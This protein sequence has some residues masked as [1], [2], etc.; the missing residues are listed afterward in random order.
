MNNDIIK[1][2]IFTGCLA[3]TAVGA[4]AQNSS[5][6][7][8][9]EPSNLPNE[10]LKN[11]KNYEF[12]NKRGMRDLNPN[13]IPWIPNNRQDPDNWDFP[14]ENERETLKQMGIN[15]PDFD[16]VDSTTDKDLEEGQMRQK[17]HTVEHIIYAMPGDAVSLYP[18]YGMEEY[19]TD[20]EHFLSTR[21]YL[22]TFSHWYDYK[23]GGRVIHTA[24]DGK[25][26]DL[27][28]FPHDRGYM[29]ISDNYGFYGGIYMSPG[30]SAIP[31]QGTKYIVST[32]K[33]YIDAVNA[34]NAAG[35][36]GRIVLSNDID[37][38]GR[39][40]VSMLGSDA[41][42]PFVGTIDGNGHAIKNLKMGGGY[43]VGL[44]SN[45]GDGASIYNLVLDNCTISGFAQ[46]GLVGY[47]TGGGL[48][49]KNLK[50]NDNCSIYATGP[51]IEGGG[52]TESFAGSILGRSNNGDSD[53]HLT[54]EN[55]YLGA[56]IGNPDNNMGFNTAICG[57]LNTRR[58]STPSIFKNIVV[59]CNILR[60]EELNRESYVRHLL[61][62]N[63]Y[64][65]AAGK[66]IETGK[67]DDSDINWTLTFENCYG[68]YNNFDAQDLRIWKSFN[69]GN[70]PD[71]TGWFEIIST[72]DPNLGGELLL[73]SA[74]RPWLGEED[75]EDQKRRKA[76]TSAIFYFPESLEAEWD[77]NGEYV[78]AADF[79]QTFYPDDNH[80]KVNEKQ[81]IE[82]LIAFRHIFRIRDA[83]KQTEELQNHN[84][85][86]ARGHQHR[87]TAR[88][89]S[90]FQIRLDSPL[91][92]GWG[93]SGGVTNYY[94]KNGAGKYER[95][96]QFGIKVLD[97]NDHSEL[98][99]EQ[100]F[101]FGSDI[102]MRR[103]HSSP[104]GD[105]SDPEGPFLYHSMLRKGSLPSEKHYI[106]QV[107]AKDNNGNVIRT[108]GRE[109]VLMQYDINFVSSSRASLVTE[110]E[111]YD[112]D[113]NNKYR[114][115]RDESLRE[116]YGD[117]K[118][119]IDFDNFFEL[120]KLPDDDLKK[121]MISYSVFKFDNGIPSDE[122]WYW[123]EEKNNLV[124]WDHYSENHL[125]S[126]SKMQHTFYKWPVAW[127]NSTY[128]FG[129]N[130]R[131]NY[132][133]YMLATH[134]TNVP[135]HAS[136]D[137][138]ENRA[139][140]IDNEIGLYDRLYY[141]TKRQR[142]NNPDKKIKQEQG[143]FY[144]VNA[145]SDPG[146]SARLPVELPC[147]GSR[148]I[149]SAWIAEL[150]KGNYDPDDGFEA[151][152]LSFNFVAV[153]KENN[154]RVV[155][156]NFI[157]GNI[158]QGKLGQWCNIYYS[159]IPRMSEFYND[160]K[161]FE[162]VDH[163]EL[164]LAHNGESSIGADYAIDDIRA[165][166]VPSLAEAAHDGFA[167]DD[168]ALD[169][170]VETS[171]E[172]LIEKLGKS[173]GYGDTNVPLKLYYAIT[174][175][176]KFD[177][178]SSMKDAVTGSVLFSNN[179]S[180]IPPY[181]YENGTRRDDVKPGTAYSVDSDSSD[182]TIVFETTAPA[183]ALK[184]GKEYYV[185]FKSTLADETADL[186]NLKD[187]FDLGEECSYF[188]TMT[189]KPSLKIKVDGVIQ[190][191]F[192][193]LEVCENQSPVIQLNVWSTDKE[194]VEVMKNAFF[195]WF[196]G[197]LN[198]FE[199]YR[200]K[201]YA[202]SL[203]ILD[204]YT[205][206]EIEFSLREALEVFR[207]RYP[208][209]ETVTGIKPETVKGIDDKYLEQWMLD[210]IDVASTP[211][212][213]GLPKLILHQTSFVMPP[214]DLGDADASKAYFVAIPI[215][216]LLQDGD[217]NGNGSEFSV[218]VC[219]SPTEIGVAVDN[220]T[221]LVRHGLTA[222]E[223]DY[224][225]DLYDIPLR[226]GLNQ[227][228]KSQIAAYPVE[229]RRLNMPLRL[230]TSSDG[231]AKEFSLV[232]EET[233]LNNEKVIKNGCI[234]LAQTNDPEYK[235]L[236]T[237]NERNEETEHL[238]WVG[239]MKEFSASSNQTADA[240]KR[241]Y[242]IAE[243][244][245]NF[246][247]KEGYFYRMRYQ[248]EELSDEEV[249]GD[250]EMLCKGQDVF[251]IKVVPQY[252]KWT[253]E[254]NLSWDNDENWCRLSS[255][256][257]LKNDMA[258]ADMRFT[259]GQNSNR[260]AYAPLAFT[261]VVVDK[262][263]VS[264]D[265]EVAAE[266]PWLYAPKE[267]KVAVK[268]D[269]KIS[270]T[271][272][273]T[274][275]PA[276]KDGAVE[277]R[278]VDGIG[279]PTSLIQYDMTA[280]MDAS[281][282]LCHPW[283]ANSC[284]EIHFLPGATVMNQQALNYQKAWVDVELDHSRWYLLSTPLQEVYA[285]DFYLPS[286]NA[287]QGTE[288]FKDIT[289][290]ES[291]N[292]RFSPAVYQRGWDKSMA[293]VYDFGKDEARNVAVKTFW[294]RVY[295]D[296]KENYGYGNAFSIK[297]DISS[298]DEDVEKVI[299]RLPKADKSYLYYTYGKDE[300]DSDKEFSRDETKSGRLNP[301]KGSVTVSTANEGNYFLVGNPFMTYMDVKK[302]LDVNTCLNKKYW[303][304]TDKGQIAVTF[305]GDTPY[306]AYP[307]TDSPEDVTVVA[308]MQGFFV[309]ADTK[310]SSLTLNYDETMM[311]RY[312][313]SD[314]S[315]LIQATRSENTPE[316]FK[317][318]SITEGR[319]CSAAIVVPG[320]NGNE[321]NSMNAVDNRELDIPSTVFT[322]KGGRAMSINFCD[323]AEGV[324]I[325]VIA[326]DQT[327]TTLRFEGGSALEGFYLYDTADNSLTP[328]SEVNEIEVTGN[329]SGRFYLT[330]GIEEKPIIDGISW[331]VDGNIL[332]VHDAGTTGMLD[333][334]VCDTLG[335]VIF[336][337][338][339]DDTVSVPLEK[340]LFVV[341][342]MNGEVEKSVKI[343]L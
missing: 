218:P 145:A 155:L 146:V 168:T 219:T 232:K 25:K 282:I 321:E 151:A 166:V 135:Y 173:E 230:V 197:S 316:V 28:D 223:I 130:Y 9:Q 243:F 211:G 237:V 295:N 4:A 55:V 182:R 16:F 313:V 47:H 7:V 48:T 279:N 250:D 280:Y 249:N 134:T 228:C 188:C 241:N 312:D 261:D 236:G 289:F 88:V 196:D 89:G 297:T 63:P 94:F 161:T 137:R 45:A 299:F 65:D 256:D 291:I 309:E 254:K 104:D 247:F 245:G 332:T 138:V 59:N 70:L 103:A 311:R 150:T 163:F 272:E 293:A 27:L 271:N 29:Q 43:S 214:V 339:G 186:S 327:S 185:V 57:W 156:H 308:P 252:M 170:K 206:E 187:F 76:G 140:N 336:K 315:T 139:K 98:P 205:E 184:V 180:K 233:V 296:V 133:M 37:F 122:L 298:L 248:F 100:G 87:V 62:N 217:G 306:A 39:T 225:A 204:D 46:V 11:L 50:I 56:S 337:G 273:W 165:Y 259:N 341:K 213:S 117:T 221:P 15:F 10:Y 290:D 125:T 80:I 201:N 30:T 329:V 212:K 325:G 53:N 119:K 90:D 191:G 305:S 183:G 123:K 310:T 105:Y 235:N 41:A 143:Y 152:N 91:P 199:N 107:I 207:L 24:K 253:G 276:M 86:Y 270:Q 73:T 42:R 61:G 158:P 160:T 292:D 244:D 19:T 31:N 285:G 17:T 128:G 118:F 131:Y 300:K 220:R 95:V 176:E 106:V 8:E 132:N 149:V 274:R 172:T 323:D 335:R 13:R 209:A 81:I 167:C 257:I 120:N 275:I 71:M 169:I 110:D 322:A 307:S 283:V 121:K 148:V 78:I 194:P 193:S 58:S 60:Y 330:A 303:I 216:G 190:P 192:N 342:M 286:D 294:S 26:Y 84:D 178:T 174:D 153:M 12:V 68:N 318:T 278:Y 202:E 215:I 314:S 74:H 35:G 18:Y 189:V 93:T 267:D 33:E 127:E 226:L 302:F 177:E 240:V 97:G 287:R 334:T 210:I 171:F 40:D 22:E 284:N 124:V 54:I 301:A 1:G 77:E 6:Q 331:D 3:L 66:W 5:E 324:E 69:A 101:T 229:M 113:P 34:I 21:D 343:R 239:E 75:G 251:T 266:N 136:A 109:M 175:K 179:Y 99:G 14:T 231:K 227:L 23:S 288:L 159:F 326:D 255:G 203:D 114:H 142:E 246:K 108:G 83:R 96:R 317:V 340:G 258:P 49:V 20:N 263:M 242:F 224:P 154:E 200:F 234:L 111:L 116:K 112:P 115:A 319:P 222:P 67:Y 338:A 195:D 102:R 36:I 269:Y 64:Q 238:L 328:V 32:V 147:A 72:E 2:L 277:E 141:K 304:V 82:P 265:D 268:D 38:S 52:A 51:A 92:T 281:E 162:D 79:S 333:V 262:V 264:D 181:T 208:D 260:K 129:Y 44:V 320:M 164:E 126:P 157:T 144:Y 198:D 85:D